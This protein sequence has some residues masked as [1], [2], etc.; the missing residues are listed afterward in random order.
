MSAEADK[1]LIQ[2]L[3]EINERARERK[4]QK[5]DID[6]NFALELGWNY[7]FTNC[8]LVLSFVKVLE[9]QRIFNS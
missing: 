8:Y 1:M 2:S 3:K 5:E 6:L 7:K 9:N 4:I